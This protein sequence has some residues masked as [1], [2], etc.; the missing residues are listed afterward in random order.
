MDFK[1]LDKIRHEVVLRKEYVN[2]SE[3]I[4][5]ELVNNKQINSFKSY[6]Y[7]F[8]PEIILPSILVC[9]KTNIIIDGHHRYYVLKTLKIKS[10]P[11]SFIDYHSE[12]ILTDRKKKLSKEKIIKSAKNKILYP[13][14]TSK[15]YIKF[16]NQFFPLGLI[17]D[18]R[19]IY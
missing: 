12:I 4:P 16:K 15:H 13:S 17:S 14:K 3:L 10:V 11:V 2:Y 8:M 19:L 9:N 6:I 1:Q 7:N 5:H 18:L